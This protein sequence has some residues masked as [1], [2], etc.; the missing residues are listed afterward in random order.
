MCF[1]IWN[2][3]RMP[4]CC[5]WWATSVRTEKLKGIFKEIEVGMKLTRWH[6]PLKLGFWLTDWYIGQWH[7]KWIFIQNETK[8]YYLCTFWHNKCTWKFIFC[9]S[10][11]VSIQRNISHHFIQCWLCLSFFHPR[12][13]FVLF[14]GNFNVRTKIKLPAYSWLGI[15]FIRVWESTLLCT[16]PLIKIQEINPDLFNIYSMWTC[17][18][19]KNMNTWTVAFRGLWQASKRTFVAYLHCKM[20]IRKI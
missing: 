9:G 19:W 15:W 5:I 13:S 3:R 20:F 6:Y 1:P 2:C 8:Q 17:H 14:L 4:G 18:L 7:S 12:N 16:V 11:Y 10:L